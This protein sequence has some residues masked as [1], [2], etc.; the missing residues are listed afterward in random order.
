[1]S[2][3]ADILKDHGYAYEDED[4]EGTYFNCQC[5]QHELLD[6]DS[7]MDISDWLALH[8]EVQLEL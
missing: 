3:R 5:G 8:Q 6:W 2:A 1:M 4:E 7:E